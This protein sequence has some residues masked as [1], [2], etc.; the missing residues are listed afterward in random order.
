MRTV[1]WR[2]EQFLVLAGDEPGEA[3]AAR[4]KTLAQVVRGGGAAV[5]VAGA[6]MEGER[7]RGGV[8][9]AGACGGELLEGGAGEK[10]GGNGRSQARMCGR[11][12]QS[13]GD[14]LGGER[15]ERHGRWAVPP[16][17]RR[18]GARI[19]AGAGA[20]VRDEAFQCGQGEPPAG[21]PGGLICERGSAIGMP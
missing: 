1:T 18:R 11:R 7:G 9:V 12:V 19:G 4:R 3:G 5:G 13:V 17:D 16:D 6:V 8:V 15:G 20:V 10:R 2:G 21:R 14:F